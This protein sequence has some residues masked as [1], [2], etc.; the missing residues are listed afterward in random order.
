MSLVASLKSLESVLLVERGTSTAHLEG[1]LKR[2]LVH[3]PG[4]IQGE[5]EAR[6]R[7]AD[8]WPTL[9]NRVRDKV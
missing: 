7:T 2:S 8:K 9:G 3:S 1:T 5:T 4:F 6:V